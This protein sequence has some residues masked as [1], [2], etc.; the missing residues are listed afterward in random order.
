MLDKKY[1]E[2]TPVNSYHESMLIIE[3]LMGK[4]HIFGALCK[5]VV[6]EDKKIKL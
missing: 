6:S 4:A 5:N 1:A 3:K 2:K